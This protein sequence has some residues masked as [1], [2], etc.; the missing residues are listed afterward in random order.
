MSCASLRQRP[1]R[2]SLILAFSLGCVPLATADTYRCVDETGLVTFSD[3]YCG[4]DAEPLRL[5]VI[6]PGE[7][8]IEPQ[9]R[10]GEIRLLED[11]V[12][13]EL[14]AQKSLAQ[15]AAQGGRYRGLD[16]KTYGLLHVG[17]SE[18]EVRYIAGPPDMETI[19]GVN[20][21]GGT[22][23]KSYYYIKKGHNASVTRIRFVN[24]TVSHIERDL[25]TSTPFRR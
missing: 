16:L 17:M 15:R 8:V 20:T 24:G 22:T 13:R 23:L 7:G 11:A 5:E 10:P 1:P 4:E 6:P 3:G 12:E 25:L 19:D 14:Q 18:A 9:L 2:L 21:F